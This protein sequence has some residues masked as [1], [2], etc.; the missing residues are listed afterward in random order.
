MGDKTGDVEILADVAWDDFHFDGN[1]TIY[2]SQDTGLGS[3]TLPDGPL[4]T[5]VNSTTVHGA[6][7]VTMTPDKKTV[8]FTTRGATPLSGQVFEVTL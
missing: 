1:A 8:Y 5:L 3:F 6:T 4:V 7:S 2:G